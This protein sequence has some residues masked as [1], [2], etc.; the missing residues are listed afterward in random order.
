MKKYKIIYADPPWTPK[1]SEILGKRWIKINKASPQK[2]YFTMSV[3]EISNL[4]V[5]SAEQAHLYLW[6]VNP[7]IDWGYKVARS[8]GF[9]VWQMLTWCKK[10]LGVG[11]FQCNT[12]HLLVCRKGERKGNPFG[13]TKGTY[14]MWDRGKHSQKPSIVKKLIVEWS[15]DLPRIELFAREKTEGWDVWGNEVESD[16]DLE[17]N[18]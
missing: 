7:H 5:P 13:F 6:V 18:P 4:N 3:D 9:E 14:F 1:I 16:I 15:G 10:G 12:E 2:H 11:R 17:A 8:W